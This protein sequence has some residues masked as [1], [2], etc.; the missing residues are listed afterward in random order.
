MPGEAPPAPEDR[1]D[2]RA[3]PPGRLHAGVPA[4]R[5]ALVALVAC[6]VALLLRAVLA[7]LLGSQPLFLLAYPASVVAAWYGGFLPGAAVTLALAV[8]TPWLAGAAWDASTLATVALYLP[9]GLLIA[10]LCQSLHDARTPLQQRI[11]LLQS[12]ALSEARRSA[13]LD[14]TGLTLFE[15]DAELRFVWVQNPPL[16][17]GTADLIGRRAEDLFSPA[18]AE[19]LRAAWLE[20]LRG[21]APLRRDFPL[22]GPR[23]T[24]V[25]EQV[26][27]PLREPGRAG[28][29]GVQGACSDVTDLRAAGARQAE[30]QAV[31]RAVQD[32]SRDPFELL[33]PVRAGG[34]DPERPDDGAIIDFVWE[35]ANPAAA[36][37]CGRPAAE[38]VGHR[39]LARDGR[40]AP[41]AFQLARFEHWREAMA[42]PGTR[43]AEFRRERDG[44]TGFYRCRSVRI[45]DRLVVTTVDATAQSRG[46]DA[47]RSARAALQR[48]ARLKDDFLAHLSHELRTPLNA[49]SGWAHLLSHTDGDPA[50]QQ[51][52]AE[53]IGR[54][55]RSQAGLIEELLD[56]NR[57]VTGRLKLERA[58]L[59]LGGALLAAVEAARPAA[60]A[61]WIRLQT[62]GI[63]RDIGC[64]GD[65]GRLRQ[66]F[67]NLLHNAVKFTPL[68]GEV[69]VSLERLDGTVMVEVADSGEGVSAEMLPHVFERY[70][71]PALPGTARQSG[72]G[73]GLAIVKSLVEAH[74]GRVSLHSAGPGLG[75]TV[76]LQLPALDL[77]AGTL[78][79]RPGETPAA[80][81]AAEGD[82]PLTWRRILVLEDEADSLELM[83]VLLRRH[84][85]IV[86]AFDNAEQALAA[87][88]HSSFDLVISDLGLP[89]MDGLEFMRRLQRRPVPLKAIAL[90]AYAGDSQREEALQAGYSRVETKPISPPEF[91]A[92]VSAVLAE[93]RGVG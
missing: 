89:G 81:P 52:A 77:D 1:A 76:R 72:L 50:L 67:G 33:R 78:A 93:T 62:Q 24:R 7:P 75:T 63:A 73:L 70:Q 20:V 65:A 36:T 71:R 45:G 22:T 43:L 53:A 30:A 80:P 83:S 91:I 28:P 48:G 26:I 42:A 27:A 32:Q 17:Y 90:T 56:M 21:G 14:A 47:E 44:A 46:L 25:L 85:A 5:A 37:L 92:T 82:A 31:F 11:R 35:Y 60:Q 6:G 10:A 88:E 40:E 59:E 55:A 84:G 68:N 15:L 49:I 64:S 23:G 39:L 29:V 12:G 13:A 16:G 79:G 69:R 74:G 58:P 86:R 9:F 8:L 66:V 38:L 51:R 61:R 41:D 54:N 2:D 19:R 4:W 57:I 34:A 18:Q 3:V 87:A